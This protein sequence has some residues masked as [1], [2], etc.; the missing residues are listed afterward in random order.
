MSCSDD[1]TVRCW[2]LATSTSV[3][4]MRG[5]ADYIRTGGISQSDGSLWFTGSYDHLVKLWDIRTGE[6][7]Q[8]LCHGAPLECILIHPAGSICFS[9]GICV[10][11]TDMRKGEM[12]TPLINHD[13]VLLQVVTLSRYGMCWLVVDYWPASPITKRPSPHYA[14]MVPTI[15]C[16]LLALTGT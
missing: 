5:H 14:L 15:G 13:C 10:Y 11:I 3:V 2:D 12:P 6:C 8:S 16:C 1:T 7:V 4:T 9:A